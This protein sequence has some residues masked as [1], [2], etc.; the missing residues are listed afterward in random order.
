MAV[1]TG[2]ATTTNILSD[3]L[4]IDLGDQISLLEP[5]AQPLA[6]FS[7]KAEKKRTVATKFSW[8]EDQSKARFAAQSGGATSSATTVAVASG[9]GV[10]FQQWDQ[11]LNTRTGEQFRVDGVNVDTLTVTR[12][13]GST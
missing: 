13:I 6:V 11:V 7:R 12:A 10:Y 4:A 5:S 3:Q 2:A 1:T 8:L 9:Q